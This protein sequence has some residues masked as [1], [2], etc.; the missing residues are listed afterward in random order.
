MAPPP[1]RWVDCLPIAQKHSVELLFDSFMHTMSMSLANVAIGALRLV[2]LYVLWLQRGSWKWTERLGTCNCTCEP[3][4]SVVL[5]IPSDADPSSTVPIS[6]GPTSV[7]KPQVPAVVNVTRYSSTEEYSTTTRFAI[8][9]RRPSLGMRNVTLVTHATLDRRDK[10]FRLCLSWKGPMSLA[11]F[12]RPEDNSTSDVFSHLLET[13]SGSESIRGSRCLRRHADIHLVRVRPETIETLGA[14][15]AKD[16]FSSYP[17]NVQ[18]NAALD[19]TIGEWVFL[20]DADFQMFP[21]A[22]ASES[23]VTESFHRAKDAFHGRRH[24]PAAQRAVSVGTAPS[25]N[26]DLLLGNSVPADLND[27]WVASSRAATQPGSAV[28][29]ADLQTDASTLLERQLRL[30]LRAA[31]DPIFVIPC[32]ESVSH[33][34]DRVPSDFVALREQVAVNEVCAFYEHHCKSCHG[35][36]RFQVFLRHNTLDGEGATGASRSL[37]AFDSL[38]PL[39][40]KEAV[41]DGDVTSD[42]TTRGG[43]GKEHLPLRN[44]N[45]DDEPQ[46]QLFFEA[47]YEEGYEPYT[48][49]SKT[50]LPRYH[51]GFVGRGYDKMS[52]FY[53]L[54]AAGHPF[55]LLLEGPYLFHS[56]RGDTPTTISQDFLNRQRENTLV[57]QRFRSDVWLQYGRT[58]GGRARLRRV[59][60]GLLSASLGEGGVEAEEFDEQALAAAEGGNGGGVHPS[61]TGD[62]DRDRLIRLSLGPYVRDERFLVALYDQQ[63]LQGRH[64]A[65]E[66]TTHDG[67][68][69]DNDGNSD[70]GAEALVKAPNAALLSSLPIPASPSQLVNV[71]L[72]VPIDW[73]QVSSSAFAEDRVCVARNRSPALN[74]SEVAILEA[75][76]S[77]ACGRIN[78]SPLQP[79]GVRYFP[80]KILLHAD[81]AFD[82]YYRW[83]VAQGEAP[84]VACHFNGAAVLSSCNPRCFGCTPRPSAQDG[85]LGSALAWLCGPD[86]LENCDS[87]LNALDDDRA[88]LTKSAVSL[89]WKAKSD[90][91]ALAADSRLSARRPSLINVTMPT[92]RATRE[93][94]QVLFSFYFMLHR[95]VMS[96]P[97]LGCHFSGVGMRTECSRLE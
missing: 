25:Q 90:S 32:L 86:G 72:F 38:K 5:A 2:T 23:A 16:M 97:D 75:A 4:D 64:G 31:S 40:Q 94:A 82:R 53:E 48:L 28:G 57:M 58:A 52:F 66:V 39:R 17:F 80:R 51:E 84:A 61:G 78:C 8:A 22:R 11:V 73:A 88:K 19:G 12:L 3:S 93:K 24:R 49:S 70:E 83:A 20:V 9:E 87:V 74:A 46:K 18:R 14:E 50:Q 44:D 7:F 54:Y 60:G 55:M 45:D 59:R 89:W 34:V 71:P 26:W 47:Y 10:L 81:W 33:S 21:A 6:G 29:G 67:P 42:P 62:A 43:G 1:P 69:N 76:L 65:G 85:R 91:G 41:V 77:Y 35:P 95:C 92:A 68:P 96:S 37:G 30:E 27:E 63:L 13:T 15:A 36:S 56:G 79:G